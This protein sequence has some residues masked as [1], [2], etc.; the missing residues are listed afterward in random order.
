MKVSL[1]IVQINLHRSAQ[2]TAVLQRRI[3][4]ERLDVALI[5]EP[6][7]F[8]GRIRNLNVNRGRLIFC[9]SSDRPRAGILIKD[10]TAIPLW[11]HC[12]ADLAAIKVTI[13]EVGHSKELVM[14][15]VYMPYDSA[16]PPPSQAV[17]KLVDYCRRKGWELILGCDA[18]AHHT[19]WGS[20]GTNRRG[21]ELLESLAGNNLDILNRGNTPTFTNSIREEVIDLTLGSLGIYDLA[22]NWKVSDEPS[23]SDHKH[24]TFTVGKGTPRREETF[25][26]NPR[27]TEWSSYAADLGE[28]L[29]TFP[30]PYGSPGEIDIATNMLRDAIIAAY[31]ENCLLKRRSK[32]DGTWWNADLQK[33]RR[34]A[35]CTLNRAK[36][37]KSLEA[38]EEA[39]A[40]QREYRKATK[41]A[42]RQ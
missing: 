23:L 18:N 41:K 15:S 24:I 30:S 39:K 17:M 2:A 25:F 14:A 27:C 42:R 5:Q 38:S 16:D 8:R 11:E 40:A 29:K 34:R 7:T 3:I 13:G 9:T 21:R 19:V 6:W 4:R 35:R 32:S 12:N 20:S 37:I 36:K 26:R 31:E 10:E 1:K 28:R 33:L 22:S